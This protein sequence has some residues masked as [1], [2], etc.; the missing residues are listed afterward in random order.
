MGCMLGTIK[1]YV[2]SKS[3]WVGSWMKYP[4]RIVQYKDKASCLED[5]LAVVFESWTERGITHLF[6]L[7]FNFTPLILT[8]DGNSARLGWYLIWSP[9]LF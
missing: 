6:F 5:P 3:N 9:W 1:V 4:S 8:I 2:S 7:R